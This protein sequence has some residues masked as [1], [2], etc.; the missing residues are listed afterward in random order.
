MKTT[1]VYKTLT[2]LS[3]F[4]GWL[5][6]CRN[7]GDGTPVERKEKKTKMNLNYNQRKLKG[8]YCMLLLFPRY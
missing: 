5:V 7:I 1:W 3:A 2:L 8:P 4:L 6:Y